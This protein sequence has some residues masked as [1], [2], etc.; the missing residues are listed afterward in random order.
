[1]SKKSGLLV[2]AADRERAERTGR[3]PANI[4]SSFLA[5]VNHMMR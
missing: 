1:M 5:V 3:V 2:Q 4:V